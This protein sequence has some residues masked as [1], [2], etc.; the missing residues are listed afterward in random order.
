MP[1]IITS[2]GRCFG[3]LTAASA[4]PAE[5]VIVLDPSRV[6]SKPADYEG[7]LE[8]FKAL[9]ACA[10][11]ALFA[12]NRGLY[13]T[14]AQVG[15]ETWFILGREFTDEVVV[16]LLSRTLARCTKRQELQFVLRTQEGAVGA[17]VLCAPGGAGVTAFG[18]ASLADELAAVQEAA[19]GQL[20]VVVT[21]CSACAKQ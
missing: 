12:A 3:P 9:V 6:C 2:T 1:P 20:D 16:A 4:Q 14:S 7:T 10:L 11:R 15:S 13:R 5:R 17:R 19:D 21:R 18:L 8:E